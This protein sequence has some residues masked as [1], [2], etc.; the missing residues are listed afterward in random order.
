M[1]EIFKYLIGMVVGVLLA[2]LLMSKCSRTTTV[3][4]VETQVDTVYQEHVVERADTI[5][6]TVVK[7][8]FDTIEKIIE[9]PVEPAE[10]VEIY[11]YDEF[12]QDSSYQITGN[13]EY[14][15]EIVS[16]DQMLIQRKDN[17]VLIPTTKTIY[18][19]RDIIKKINTT[20]Q[21]RLLVGAYTTFDALE[22][23]QAGLDLTFVD[24]KFRQYT[25][26]KDLLNKE[27]FTLGLKIPL[28][29]GN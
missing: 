25:V 24:N 11:A 23:D 22:L 14:V 18:R 13:I 26:G 6:Q 2:W 1:K 3:T 19:N 20:R 17:I 27:S 15:G 16:H 9:V 5:Y 21:P 7:T 10:E 8:N 4:V 29:Y 28:L 12:Y